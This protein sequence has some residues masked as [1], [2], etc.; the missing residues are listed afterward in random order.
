MN[1]SLQNISFAVLYFIICHHLWHIKECQGQLLA[2]LKLSLLFLPVV[3]ALA[4]LGNKLFPSMQDDFDI[5]N[6]LGLCCN[7]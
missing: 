1:P 3:T 7:D 5:M 6:A 2:F 4:Y